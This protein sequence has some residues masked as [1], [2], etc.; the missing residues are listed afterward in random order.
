MQTKLK[1]RIPNY[2]TCVVF[3]FLATEFLIN[4]TFESFFGLPVE[5]WNQI[6]AYIELFLLLIQLIAFQKYTK[7]ELII[8]GA[9]AVPVIIS[10]VLSANNNLMSFVL[11]MLACKDTEL[12][13]LVRIMYRLSLVLIPLVIILCFA[14]VLEDHTTYRLSVLRHSLGFAHPNALGQR[15]FLFFAC[16]CYLRFYSLKWFDGLLILLAAFFC[17]AVPNSQTAVILLLLM[18][19]GILAYKIS[20]KVHWEYVFGIVLIG[21]SAVCNIFSIIF[22]TIDVKHY[23]I[24]RIFDLTLSS[25]FSVCH[26]IIQLFG[27]PV[28]GQQVLYQSDEALALRGIRVGHTL[29]LDNAYCS[30]LVTFGIVI[31]ILFSVVYCCNMA[32]QLKKQRYNLVFILFLI[33]VYGI[34]ERTLF[35]ISLNIFLVSASDLIYSTK[36]EREDVALK[37][38]EFGECSKGSE[39]F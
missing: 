34:M 26:E 35:I 24:L 15:I 25:R 30:I 29:F 6:F 32:V 13:R 31:F 11:F 8:I 14:G 5:T 18:F 17:Y 7:K 36:T 4:T 19:V 2:F 10:T 16:H 22:C 21:L 3:F 37:R 27:I 38:K 9:I 20:E 1:V 39:M 28:F 33:A 23:P 12:D